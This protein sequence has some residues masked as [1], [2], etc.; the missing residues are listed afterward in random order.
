[1]TLRIK[2]IVSL[3]LTVC[4]NA[5]NAASL[6]TTI[7]DKKYAN[8]FEEG[9]GL[10]LDSNGTVF[11]TSNENGTLV[12]I[13]NGAITTHAIGQKLFT[14]NDLNGISL[15]SNNRL[16]LTSQGSSSIAI[17]DD[18]YKA[19]L[20][21]SQ[22]GS[23]AGELDS[24][25]ALAS[26]INGRIFVADTSNNRISV[27]NT[28]G[29]FLYS[30]GD[31]GAT[32]TQLKRP[33]HIALDANENVYV[34]EKDSSRISIYDRKGSLLKQLT[35]QAIAQ[36]FGTA[37]DINAMAVDSS[38]LIYFADADSRKVAQLDW[39]ENK[40][41]ESFGS[42]GQSQGQFR[43]IAQLAVNDQGQVAVLDIDNNKIEL[44]QLDHKSFKPAIKTDVVS[45]QNSI[46]IDCKSIHAF[47]DEQS[48]CIKPEQGIAIV[49][50]DGKE[51]GTF[52]DAVK[53]P[54]HLHVGNTH[55]AIIEGNSLH[56]YSLD[57]QPIYK[58]GRYGTSPGG[59]NQPIFV[60]AINDTTYVA[61]KKNNRIQV[62]AKD[63]Q[64]NRQIV[65]SDDPS[66]A[67][68]TVGQMLVTGSGQLIV[69]DPRS[70]E[71]SVSD[72]QTG[73]R[74]KTLNLGE[75]PY[76]VEE[77]YSIDVDQQGRL[78]VLAKT[79]AN[80]YSVSV[81]SNDQVLIRFGSAEGNGISQAFYGP[82]DLSVL[83]NNKNN[84]LVN[85]RKAKQL[86]VYN[87]KEIPQAAFGLKVDGNKNQVSLQWERS[88][89]NLVASYIVE[90]SQNEKGPYKEIFSSEANQKAI[91]AS[92]DNV[93][94]RVISVSGHGLK[95]MPSKAKQND[96]KALQ[97]LFEAKEY[98]SIIEK[99]PKLLSLYP[100][101]ADL[102]NLY[103]NSLFVN[104]NFRDAISAFQNLAKFSSYKHQALEKQVQ[105]HYELEEFLDAKSLIDEVLAAQPTDVQPYLICTELSLVLADAIGAVTCAED[106]L[107]QHSEHTELR[108]LLGKSY[109]A[110][111]L[112]DE[113]LIA[114]DTIIENKPNDYD[115]RVLIANDLYDL[116]Q[117][118]KALSHFSFVEQANPDSFDAKNGKAKVLIA[119]ERYDE[120]KSLA[121]KLSGNKQSKSI[122]ADGYYFLGQIAFI[123]RKYT[124]AVLR[125]TRAS[126]Y[127]AKAIKAWSLLAQSYIE[128]NKLPKGV[129]TLNQGIKKNPEA[130][131]LY[132]TL[133][134]IELTQE[135][136]PEAASALTAAV[137]LMPSS[138]KAQ[139]LLAQSLFETRN[140]GKAAKHAA[141]AARIAPNDI[142]VLVLEADIAALQ[143]KVGSA[144]DF[145]KTALTLKPTSAD[146]HFRLGRV[147]QDA[148]I[149]DASKIHLE[150][151]A[152]INPSWSAP[153]KALGDLYLKRRLFDQ[154][155]VSYEKAIELEPS[156][157]NRAALNVAFSDKKRALEFKNNAPQ[158]VL[159]D[160]N[161]GHV[162]SA[163]YKRYGDEPIGKVTLE[164][165]GATDYGDLS[166]SFQIKE[167]MDFPE[168]IKI[169]K[170]AGSSEKSFDIK[171]T[172]NNKILQ[173][174]EDTGVQVEV[175]L[176][177]LRDGQKDDITLTQTMT[178]Y[179]KNAMV[180]GDAQMVGSFVTPKDDSLR[181]FVRN[182]MSNYQPDPGPL[183]DK[184]VSAMSLFSSLNAIGTKYI[185][186]P[187]TPYASLTDDQ[188][189][190][191]QFPRETLRL[192]SGDCD[193]LSVLFSA[194]LENLGINTAL[195]EVPGHLL[196]MFDTGLSVDDANLVSRDS[197]LLAVK[198][199]NIWIP[200]ESTMVSNSFSE[201]WA[202]GARKYQ[203]AIKENNLGIISLKQA[204]STYKPVTLEKSD[205]VI[206]LPPVEQ[207]SKLINRENKVLL[208]KSIDRLILP[209]Q[210]MVAGDPG[211][212]LARMQIAILYSRFGLFDEAEQ[213]YEE[214]SELSPNNV[215]ILNNK[216]N[217]W[218]LQ[219]K[220]D[221][222]IE[223][224]QQAQ[225][226]DTNDG[227]VKINLAMA[228]YAKGDVN[229]AATS[230]N[231]AISI[232]ASLKN[233]FN[234]FGK[235][236]SK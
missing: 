152:G 104:K 37:P 122:Q 35:A 225:A 146:L 17:V 21:F 160:L 164:N 167:Y 54:T 223:T 103:A 48:L 194:G 236:L 66:N 50:A 215:S 208:S 138:L 178:I 227:S 7:D 26:S 1:M 9:A 8:I 73:K 222:A 106:G 197:S 51:I 70:Q 170:I 232:D 47:N 15:L 23:D 127:D 154:A 63:G 174:D 136:Y 191:V 151:S 182:V 230:F 111:G 198:D 96:Y 175:K 102:L 58:I 56:T 74:L 143:G 46:A 69:A 224:Y 231:E 199:G 38:G 184:I 25:L 180:W 115:T 81:W 219:D 42:L 10:V 118:E 82:S 166:L 153:Q 128:L 5:V 31:S 204:W 133:G 2:T 36:S 85:D 30:F 39:N 40:I 120:A 80:P 67:F 134:E 216:G 185:V 6:I 163:A 187:N 3:A 190:Y 155:I 116:G 213:A 148:N 110:A 59:F 78:Y 186:D 94:F 201:A 202:E 18:A 183:N 123:N 27:F 192:R 91:D 135:H 169:D 65:G 20:T 218:L 221:Q 188:V 113:G 195:I 137:D 177:Y 196:M 100:E 61:D 87:Y 142:D 105:A 83:S 41:L 64:F 117:Y 16:V 140:Y 95:S 211:N 125:L 45:Y 92:D 235:L 14:D 24:P 181:N 179:G 165:V 77:I 62:F 228:Y 43:Y 176:S 172:F 229:S 29:L 233:K 108:Y 107:A 144:I 98:D 205:F 189:D 114:F 71:L 88:P 101:N 99:A 159:R 129:S 203:K 75:E 173:V 32:S 121:I 109:I 119:L 217:F 212:I 150:K 28:Q 145:L 49:T 171:A 93:W 226:I 44:F 156:E 68:E 112:A 33:S 12:K 52:A 141:Q 79:D 147:Y 72:A 168:V 34:L 4:F 162:F 234:A 200:V 126:K 161:I 124:E 193:D 157:S 132:Q 90:G 210:A 158:L 76:R 60:F 57:N 209:Y 97:A 13:E 22:S 214:L 19:L 207:I 131:E 130:F 11:L 139:K 149:Y 220:Y 89:S 84:I 86:Q 55:V 206:P 53:E